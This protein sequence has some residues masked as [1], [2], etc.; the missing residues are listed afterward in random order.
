MSALRTDSTVTVELL[1]RIQAGQADSFDQLFDRHRSALRRAVDRRLNAK[2]RRRADASD[3]V[4]E[5]QLEAFR[6]L[7]DY[8]RRKPMPFWLWLY[9]MAHER[10]LKIERAH[11]DR[12]KR[13]VDREVPLPDQSSLQFAS[14]LTDQGVTPESQVRRREMASRVRKLLGQLSETDREIIVLRN[15]EGLSNLEAA[16]LLDLKPETAK[17]RY[18]RAL[19]RMRKTMTA[20]GLTDSEL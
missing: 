12:A 19:L 9:R 2:V 10:L 1:R 18:A 5:T 13:S 8:L 17:K 3:I 15:F 7:D 11:L 16:C 4:Q 14:Q 20:V 6:R